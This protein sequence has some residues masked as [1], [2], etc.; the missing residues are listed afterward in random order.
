MRLCTDIKP[1]KTGEVLVQGLNGKQYVFTRGE[2]GY[3]ACDVDHEP[4]VA[5][6]LRLE[7]FYPD[8]P[9]DHAAA[10]DIVGAGADDDDDSDDDLGGQ[11]GG[12][13]AL[14][15]EGAPAA[16]PVEAN[17]PPASFKP[18]AHIGR[19]GKRQTN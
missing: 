9:A 17:T 3:L 1:R 5:H 18:K 6:L 7:T 16:L 2:G 13:D 8:D 14:P 19:G 12:D 4:T 10:L 11:D 15:V